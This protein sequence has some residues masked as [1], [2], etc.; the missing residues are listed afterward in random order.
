MNLELTV[1]MGKHE[2][3]GSLMGYLPNCTYDTLVKVFGKPQFPKTSG[4]GKVKKEWHGKINGLNFTIY[5]YKSEISYK[6]NLDWHIGGDSKMVADLVTE[7]FEREV[8]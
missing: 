7:Y 2:F 5:D 3:G 6:K 4:D 1:K 8:K